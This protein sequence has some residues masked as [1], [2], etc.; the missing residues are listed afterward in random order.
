[1]SRP[2]LPELARRG[3]VH[4]MGVGGAG[5]C[6]LAEMLVRSGV[7]VSGCDLRPGA[8]TEALVALGARVE[9]GHDPAHLDPAP[10]A[11]VVSAAVPGDHPEIE[12]A[13]AAGIPVIKRAVALGEWVESGTVV[14]VAGTH[15]KTTT[16]A[17]ATEIL[18]AAGRDPTGFVGGR[19]PAWGGNL[20]MGGSDLFV[21]E[22]DEYDRSFHALTPDVAIVTNLEADHL[23][24]YG[25]LEGIREAFLHFVDSVALDGRIA[26]CG[27]D[28]GA[29]GLL[30]AAGNR[31]YSYGAHA[32]SQLRA[33][34]LTLGR[35]GSRFTVVEEGIDRGEVTLRVPGLHNVLNAL[36]AAAAARHLGVG[37]EAVAEGLRA[38]VGVDRRFQRLGE[39]ADVVVVDDYAHHPTEIEATLTAARVGFDEVS[40]RGRLVAVFQ[41]HLYSRTRD[42]AGDFGAALL[43]ADVVWVTDVYPAREAP[44]PGVTGETVVQAIREAAVNAD[45]A[46]LASAADAGDAAKRAAVEIHS[47]PALDTLPE[48]VAATLRAGDLCITLGAGSIEAVAPR[49]LGLL[50]AKEGKGNA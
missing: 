46:E 16:T 23:D 12:A 44:I 41:P 2:S 9:H 34:D 1:M 3:P 36:G 14:A 20:R 15:G 18:T 13:R 24:I 21:V 28:P 4:F 25:D 38:F 8:G 11:L 10:A 50:Q 5:M 45:A 35:A 48:A 42:F 19:V 7:E 37:W 6:A 31:G 29:S 43:L 26:V 22:A 49:I 39:A 40:G 27:D 30:A 17:M 33:V 32:G 47:H